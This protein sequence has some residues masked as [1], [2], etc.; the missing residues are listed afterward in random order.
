MATLDY[1]YSSIQLDEERYLRSFDDWVACGCRFIRT[2]GDVD[3]TTMG[4]V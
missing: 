1:S 2:S 4:Q 3:F